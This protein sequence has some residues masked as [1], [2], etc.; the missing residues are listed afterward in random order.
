MRPYARLGSRRYGFA[1][2]VDQNSD[3]EW[4]V[5]HS[6]KYGELDGRFLEIVKWGGVYTFW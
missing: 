2:A 6:S 3:E 5:A 4:R 1:L